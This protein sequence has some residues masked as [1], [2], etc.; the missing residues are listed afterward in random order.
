MAAPSWLPAWPGIWEDVSAAYKRIV[1]RNWPANLFRD[2]SQAQ[3]DLLALGD[4]L[5]MV[6]M[7][8]EWTLR[9]IWPSQ[10][11]NALFLDRWERSLGITAAQSTA[12][13]RFWIE[14]IMRLQAE[15]LTVDRF[16]AIM[17]GAFGTTLSDI[18][19]CFPTVP[20]IA[21]AGTQLLVDG[22]MELAGV[23]SWTV[24]GSAT[25]TKSIVTPHGGTNCLRVAYNAVNNPYASQAACIQLVPSHRISG[26]ARGNATDAWVPCVSLDGTIIWKGLSGTTWQFFDVVAAPT[27]LGVVQ[28]GAFPQTGVFTHVEF[29]DCFVVQ[30][31]TTVSQWAALLFSM[32]LYS[33]T[34]AAPDDRLALWLIALCQGAG[35]TWS[36]GSFRTLKYTAA[37]TGEGSAVRT[38]GFSCYGP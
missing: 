36:Y 25:L 19:I 7:L 37:A 16:R 29:D 22:D 26:W 15:A 18:A 8:M 32:H 34:N 33:L 5:S 38:M 21:A 23:A 2:G 14:A 1:P 28:Y 9:H 17:A 12:W 27:A 35:E 13:R 10:D 3:H 11:V 4:S 30:D 31:R 6:K 24:G 20:E